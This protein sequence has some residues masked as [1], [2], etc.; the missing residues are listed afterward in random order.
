MFTIPQP[1]SSIDDGMLES[2]SQFQENNYSKS[3]SRVIPEGIT[4]IRG[5]AGIADNA[6]LGPRF[7][8]I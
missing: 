3:T 5:G 2:V 6:D 4:V 8:C 7:N 1:R